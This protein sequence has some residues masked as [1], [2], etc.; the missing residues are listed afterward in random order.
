MK[1]DQLIDYNMRDITS[2][3]TNHTYN[4]VEKLYPDPFLKFKIEHISG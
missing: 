1:F 4:V 2:D 3:M